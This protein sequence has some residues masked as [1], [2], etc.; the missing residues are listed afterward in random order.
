MTD[1]LPDR[2]NPLTLKLSGNV[3]P[4]FKDNK[5]NAG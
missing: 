3:E 4:Y 2:L 1:E 5:N